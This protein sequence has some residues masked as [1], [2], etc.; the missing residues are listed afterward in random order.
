MVA[1][2]YRELDASS[3]KQLGALRNLIADPDL[4]LTTSQEKEQCP[5]K[6]RRCQKNSK[7][8]LRLGYEGFILRQ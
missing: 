3:T 4:L 6:R 7:N 1:L 2:C 5:V 8:H